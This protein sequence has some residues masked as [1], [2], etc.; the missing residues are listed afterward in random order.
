MWSPQTKR[1]SLQLRPCDDGY[2]VIRKGIVLGR[3]HCTTEP[4]GRVAF[5][6]AVDRRRKP[7]T[8]RGRQVAAA[9]VAAL[10]ELTQKA[11]SERM[12]PEE[13]VLAAWSV[14]PPSSL[15]HIKRRQR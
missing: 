8:Y 14:R 11:R 1:S 10:Y 13:I 15:K 6:L 9:A 7:R 4:S 12:S 3:I 2:E 5:L